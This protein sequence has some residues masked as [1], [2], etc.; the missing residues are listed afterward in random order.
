MRKIKLFLLFL[1]MSVIGMNA[2]IAT[3]ANG[4]KVYRGNV[5]VF[6]RVFAYQFMHGQFVKTEGLAPLSQ[7]FYLQAVQLLQQQGFN[8]VNRDEKAMADIQK[9]LAENKLEDY[10]EGFSVQ[11]K[12]VGADYILLIDLVTMGENNKVATYNTSYRL[13]GISNNVGYHQTKRY[14]YELTLDQKQLLETAKDLVTN[15][16]IDLNKFLRKSFPPR[17]VVTGINGKK[18]SMASDVPL[19]INNQD[20]KSSM[21]NFYSYRE[22]T[23]KLHD[24]TTKFDVVDPITTAEMKSFEV[25]G[26]TCW[27][28]TEDAIKE[29]P[30][31]ILPWMSNEIW[32]KNEQ[33][34][35]VALFGFPHEEA[36]LDGYFKERINDAIMSSV[37]N[38]RGFAL[39]EN[40]LLSKIKEERE[41]QKSE[42]FLDGHV[43]DQIK[44]IGANYIIHL[45]SFSKDVENPKIIS[46]VLDVIDVSSNS[47][48]KSV[49]VKCHISRLDDA[50]NYYMSKLLVNACS[51]DSN[52][53]DLVLYTSHVVMGKEDDPY[54]LALVKKINNPMTNGSQYVRVDLCTLKFKEFHGMKSVYEIDKVL[55]KSDMKKLDEY[56]NQNSLFYVYQNLE[57]PEMLKPA[58]DLDE[59]GITALDVSDPEKAQK[60]AE[61]KAKRGAFLKKIIQITSAAQSQGTD[62]NQG[63]ININIK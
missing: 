21:M 36:T 38:T 3:D 1:F 31:K 17:L 34:Q 32:F 35:T 49:N 10:L 59:E 46:F 43:A 37:C 39:I 41:L 55:D 16:K 50:L 4:F 9:T 60:K 63:E 18:V 6:S 15:S 53:K 51:I 27:L 29:D 61:R 30:S 33:I 58:T 62:I 14:K 40:E 26:E 19:A 45:S 47:I 23:K 20:T 28:K 12:S 2:Q 8:V 48:M 11:A 13:I 52:K 57:E 56:R 54:M 24:L 25:D 7:A 42:D 5:E 22:E 44:A